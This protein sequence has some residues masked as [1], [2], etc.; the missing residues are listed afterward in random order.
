MTKTLDAIRESS[1]SDEVK[2]I[3]LVNSVRKTVLEDADGKPY[4]KSIG[5]RA[6]A[7]MEALAAAGV[8]Y[9]NGE[10]KLKRY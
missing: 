1:G 4:L 2:I 5:D 7:I 8:R 3:N 10:E 6:E 9:L